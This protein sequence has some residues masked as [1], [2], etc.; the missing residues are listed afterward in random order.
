MQIVVVGVDHTTAPITLREQLAC[1]PR[2][3]SQILGATQQ[4]AQEAILLSTCNRLELYAVCTEEEHDA[5]A[6][7]LRVLSEIRQV[8]LAELEIH[9]Y[10]FIDE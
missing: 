3:V 1:S 9:S 10:H 2:Q 5:R 7:L 4:V 8:P 6:N